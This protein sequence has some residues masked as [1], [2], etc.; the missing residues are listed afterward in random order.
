MGLRIEDA[1]IGHVERQQR[2]GL[3]RV[4][5]DRQRIHDLHPRDRP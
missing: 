4:E 2:I 1:H 3:A 5:A